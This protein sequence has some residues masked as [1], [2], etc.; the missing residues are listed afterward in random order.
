MAATAI[1][2]Q[3]VGDYFENCNCDVVC[4]CVFS[5]RPFLTGKPTNGFCEVAFAFHVDQGVYENIRLDGLNA[6]VIARS[7]GTMAEGNWAAAVYLDEK[8]DDHQREALQAIFTGAAGGR[9]LGGLAPLISTVLGIKSAAITYEKRGK[10]RAVQIPNLMDMGVHPA[11]GLDPEKEIFAT[12]AH[13]FAPEGVA[14]A[15]GNEFEQQLLCE[16]ALLLEWCSRRLC[17]ARRAQHSNRG[18]RTSDGDFNVI[19]GLQGSRRRDPRQAEPPLFHDRF[20]IGA[21]REPPL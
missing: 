2:W 3:I 15:V 20:S 11:P 10:R 12:N 17:H 7:P 19:I 1:R 5:P 18:G 21:A 8:A 16:V 13:P 9:P 14:M 4:P 6:V